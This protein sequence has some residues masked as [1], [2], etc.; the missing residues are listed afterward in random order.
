MGSGCGAWL[1]VRTRDSPLPLPVSRT[2]PFLSI[3]SICQLPCM[4]DPVN[5]L[6]SVL[7]RVRCF[8]PYSL[9]SRPELAIKVS[10]PV[11]AKRPHPL[12]SAE[13]VGDMT[14][15]WGAEPLPSSISRF[16]RHELFATPSCAPCRHYAAWL[17]CA[18]PDASE[19]LFF[20]LTDFF[21][22]FVT[23]APWLRVI[24]HICSELCTLWIISFAKLFGLGACNMHICFCA[25]PQTQFSVLDHC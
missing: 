8:F 23:S 7:S 25:C 6:A 14:V 21:F 9:S 4:V 12:E 19:T 5:T 11:A 2:L 20:V 15:R 18:V 17:L 1:C 16:V 10:I 22:A 13:P 3:P 24:V